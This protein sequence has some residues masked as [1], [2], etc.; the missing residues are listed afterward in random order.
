MSYEHVDIKCKSVKIGKNC[1]FGKNVKIHCT[2]FEIGD[3]GY[4][5]DGV[6]I[7][8]GGNYGPN[9][10]VKIGKNVGIFER[11]IIN[12]SEEVT[13]GDNT[14]IGAEVMIWTHGAWLDVLQGFPSDFG[15]VKIGSN[16]WLPA[17]GIVLPNVSI[18]NNVV[19]GINSTINRSLPDGCFAAG[20]PCKVI[21]E[22][23]YPKELTDEEKTKIINEIIQDW[24]NLVEYKGEIIDMIFYEDKKI[25]LNQYGRQTIYDIEN[26]TI[27]GHNNPLVEDLRDYLRRRGIKIFTKDSFNSIKPNWMK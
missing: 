13:I 17:R 19:I 18:G 14:G 26:R 12:P 9:S 16:V 7:G 25:I 24:K 8:R 2:E 27:K 4:I 6:E 22:N 11:T 23:V 1:K 21:K 20:S 5:A 3:F 15:P 10:K